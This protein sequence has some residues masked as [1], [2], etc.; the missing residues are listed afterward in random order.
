MSKTNSKKEILYFYNDFL[1]SASINDPGSV[2]W[3]NKHSQYTRFDKLLEIGIT[4]SDSVLDLGCGLGHMVDF[5]EQKGYPLENYFGVDINSNYIVYAIQR[6]PGV[7]FSIGEIF[8]ISDKF[9]YIVGSGV[10]TVEMSLTEIFAAIEKSFQLCNKGVAF[11]FLNKEYMGDI[12][13][14]NT[15]IPEELY[16]LIK[17]RY[18]NT[19]LVTGY[20]NNEDFTVYIFK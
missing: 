6:K 18:A 19:K 8:D 3:T 10:F 2:A 16:E 12:S 20:L 5:L 1:M 14:F 9:N 11:N 7:A 4:K 17:K 15:F 13:G